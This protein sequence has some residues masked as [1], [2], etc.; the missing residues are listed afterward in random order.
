M[1]DWIR[2]IIVGIHLHIVVA[3]R[4]RV[5]DGCAWWRRRWPVWTVKTTYIWHAWL[6]TADV[7][8]VIVGSDDELDT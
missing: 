1:A 7:L 2:R 8:D 3:S 5:L 6:A 4:V